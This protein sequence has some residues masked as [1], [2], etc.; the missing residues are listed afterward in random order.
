M[1]HTS[2]QM[3]P[4]DTLAPIAVGGY[5]ICV[6]PVNCRPGKAGA[7]SRDATVGVWMREDALGTVGGRRMHRR[8]ALQHPRNESCASDAQPSQTSRS[9]AA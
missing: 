2:I 9:R 8:A 3:H 4:H 7:R 1:L 5:H 6:W